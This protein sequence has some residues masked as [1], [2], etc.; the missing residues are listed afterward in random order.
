MMFTVARRVF[1]S[2]A[3]VSVIGDMVHYFLPA[4]QDFVVRNMSL[5]VHPHG[6]VQVLSV[7]TLL[8]SSSGVFLPLEVALNR[9]W[10]VESNRP[11]LLNQVV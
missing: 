10:G 5:L 2:Q 3:M 7:L 6:G 9:V 4:N 1:H 11:Y 8:I